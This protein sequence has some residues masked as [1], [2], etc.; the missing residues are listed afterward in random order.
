[1]KICAIV[2]YLQSTLSLRVQPASDEI[3]LL[4]KSQN[5]ADLELSD[6]EKKLFEKEAAEALEGMKSF[7]PS[8][9]L[10]K[11]WM[12]AWTDRS[13]STGK[14]FSRT[15]MNM[16][17]LPAI[18]KN[19]IRRHSFQHKECVDP[20]PKTSVCQN[21]YEI[22]EYRLGDMFW[23]NWN[24]G[25]TNAYM[26][27]YFPE[28]IAAKYLKIRHKRSDI[29]A[30]MEVIDGPEY[31]AFE[32]PPPNTMVAHLRLGD[33]EWIKPDRAYQKH[34]KEAKEKGINSIVL[35]TGEHMFKQQADMKL[36]S[37]KD[38]D[39]IARRLSKTL[40]RIENIFTTAGLNV[41]TRVNYNADCDFIYMVNAPQFLMSGGS[42]SKLVKT[43]W[44]R[45]HSSESV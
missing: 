30:L 24:V 20:W 35:V 10:T 34:A 36:H 29:N 3:E 8:E 25:A 43:V 15:D 5:D 39:L 42:F 7:E 2:L 44:R 12:D 16:Q 45:K 11:A 40:K 1:M 13:S 4:D 6:E 28:S 31:Q 37:Q 26:K 41:T 32:K 17:T 19:D 22:P 9:L 38:S 14:E 23:E 27:H 33:V 18:C 21:G